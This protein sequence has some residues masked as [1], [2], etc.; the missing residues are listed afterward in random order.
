[1]IAFRGTLALGGA[2]RRLFQPRRL[3][4]PLTTF[5]RKTVLPSVR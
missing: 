2:F 1:M 5:G 4:Y 3:L